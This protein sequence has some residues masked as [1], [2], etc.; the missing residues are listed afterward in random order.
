MINSPDVVKATMPW[1]YLVHPNGLIQVFDKDG[2]EVPILD[3]MEFAVQMSV[4][5]TN[6][7]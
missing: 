7:G 5:M 3:L 1:T 2:V 6:K 4:L